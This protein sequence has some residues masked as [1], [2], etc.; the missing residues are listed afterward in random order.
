MIDFFQRFCEKKR[1]VRYP[2]YLEMLYYPSL[3]ILSVAV[4]LK[5]LFY[6]N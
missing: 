5:L 6:H 4:T 2:P 1:R 3:Q